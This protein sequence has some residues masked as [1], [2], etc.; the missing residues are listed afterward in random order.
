MLLAVAI[1]RVAVGPSDFTDAAFR[2]LVVQLSFR[3]L[4]KS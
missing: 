4:G 3:L 1:G 2:G